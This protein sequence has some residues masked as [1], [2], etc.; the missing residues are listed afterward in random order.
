VH[1]NTNYLPYALTERWNGSSW[2]IQ[3]TPVSNAYGDELVSVSCT[4]SRACTAVGD[5]DDQALVVRF[6][7]EAWSLQTP[8]VDEY[9][10]TTF[11]NGVSCTSATLCAAVGGEYDLSGH[12]LNLAERWNGSGWTQQTT[13]DLGD[14]ELD[15]VSCTSFGGCTAVGWTTPGPHAPG[16][17]AESWD[18]VRWKVQPTPF[19]GGKNGS[20][21]GVSCTRRGFCV[22]VGE[23]DGNKGPAR[24]LIERRS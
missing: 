11:F 6:N 13:P 17:V 10:Y 1:G 24:P 16:P 12:D 22:A 3:Q 18:G 5:N 19:T 7:G 15:A 4:S 9:D 20:L 8:D 14:G 23:V 2:T 21:S